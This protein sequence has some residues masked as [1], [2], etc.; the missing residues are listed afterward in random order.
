MNNDTPIVISLGGSLIVPD[1]IATDFLSYFR[2]VIEKQVKKGKR[3]AIATGGGRVA[4]KYI[5]AAQ[6]IRDDMTDDDLDWIGIYATRMN[7]HFLHH[8][9][10]D[11]ATYDIV[12]DPMDAEMRDEP[13][14]IGAGWKPGWSSDYV[15]VEIA[16]T[17]GADTVVNL[18]NVDAVY[19]DDPQ[20]NPDAERLDQLSWHEYRKLIPKKW[21]PGLS[22]P[23]DPI[24]SERAQEYGL[25][26]V[27]M[28]GDLSNL[29]NYFEGKEFEGTTI[30]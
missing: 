11:V 13:V 26:A 10:K 24:A 7:A 1:E 2:D 18:S 6:D 30:S 15:S 25:K 17:I 28:G 12:I 23:F 5:R 9:L 22:T 4:R 19:R 21:S 20:E 16:N 29:E 14:L 3:F 8:L 27:I